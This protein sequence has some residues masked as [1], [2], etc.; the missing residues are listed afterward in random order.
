[1]RDQA[2]DLYKTAGKITQTRLDN[3]GADVQV[4]D[5]AQCILYLHSTELVS[6]STCLFSSIVY[7]VSYFI[8]LSLVLVLEMVR[9]EVGGKKQFK[10]KDKVCCNLFMAGNSAEFW[11]ETFLKL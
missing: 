5:S 2:S 4:F 8:F 1:V 6:L 11:R 9:N 10:F 7:S 3:P